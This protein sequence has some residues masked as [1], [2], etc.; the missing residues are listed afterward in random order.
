MSPLGSDIWRLSPLLV[1][2]YEEMVKPHV[3]MTMPAACCP[4]FLTWWTCTPSEA[5]CQNKPFLIFVYCDGESW[6]SM[7]LYLESA[8]PQ[9]TGRACE[10]FLIGSFEVGGNTFNLV[11]TSGGSPHNW[12]WKMKLLLFSC[13]PSL[14]LV[15]SSMLLLRH[16]FAGIRTYFFRIPIVGWGQAAP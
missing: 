12:T 8:K 9:A 10:V 2:L 6:L 14:S 1:V 16:F 5:T 11:H 7:W 3:P 4:A 15:S 13:L